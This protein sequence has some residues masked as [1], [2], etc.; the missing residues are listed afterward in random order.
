MNKN[1]NL[2]IRNALI[3]DIEQIL[4]IEEESF[5]SHHWS[6]ESFINELDAK[7]SKYLVCIDKSVD[8]VIGYIGSWL[9]FDEG[10]I[11]TLAVDVSCRRNHIAD[12]LLYNLISFFYKK[13]IKWIT[14]EV[15]AS[16]FAAIFLYTKYLFKKLGI[17]KK[18]YQDNNEDALI[19]WTEDI[20]TNTFKKNLMCNY[21]SVREK[22]HTLINISMC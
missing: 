3:S 10:H 18:Y 7:Y 14:L 17:R 11:T 1:K 9:I 22:E 13:S 20:T 15:R 19:L 21:E 5:G 4:K 16:N 12:I 8:R 6:Y 2:Y